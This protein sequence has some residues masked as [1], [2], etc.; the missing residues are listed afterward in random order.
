MVSLIM[1]SISRFFV[2]A[3]TIMLGMLFV[4]CELDNSEGPDARIF[5]EIRDIETDAL[6]EQDLTNGSR[7]CYEELGFEN[8]EQQY[9]NFMV[10]GQYRNNMVFSGKYDIYFAER[11]F[12]APEKLTAYQIRPGDNRLDFR[13]LPYVRISN[14]KILRQAGDIVATFTV[15]PTV[16][17][18]VK[19]VAL[20]GHIDRVVGASFV[21]ASQK[22]SVGESFKNEGRTYTLRLEASKFTS[23][24]AYYFRV[25]AIVDAPNSKYNYATAK[26]L[27]I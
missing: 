4:S 19:E 15:T 23:G 24:E 1:K 3:V 13:V 7:I 10:D 27:T 26:R 12:V 14:V 21:K 11:N 16:D 2:V 25:G 6:V 20:F 5:G 8:P 22:Q 9:M 17:N 18:S